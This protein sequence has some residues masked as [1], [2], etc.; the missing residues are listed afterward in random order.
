MPITIDNFRGAV[1]KGD[2]S[3]IPDNF[4]VNSTAITK[5][6]TLQ[7]VKKPTLASGFA[8]KAG[9]RTVYFYRGRA[10][11]QVIAQD[12]AAGTR[13]GAGGPVD[14]TVLIPAR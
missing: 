5:N 3:A 2:V 14:F 9:A 4:A 12:P 10:Q 13:L 6:G 8:I 7:P 1:L 11:E